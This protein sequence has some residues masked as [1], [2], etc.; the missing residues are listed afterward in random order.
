[1]TDK[2]K[3]LPQLFKPGQSGNPAGKPKGTRN[4]LSEDFLRDLHEDWQKQGKDV[5]AAV[6][7]RNP[8]AYLKVVASLIPKEVPG[9]FLDELKEM[10]TEEIEQKLER[11]RRE[12]EKLTKH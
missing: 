1:M 4:R 2:R 5:L 11:L 7:K 9:H 8:A 12:R 10:S 3:T 6:R